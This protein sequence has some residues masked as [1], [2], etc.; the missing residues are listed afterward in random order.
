MWHIYN[1]DQRLQEL[2]DE[3]TGEVSDIAEMEM[4]QMEREEKIK[5]LALMEKEMELRISNIDRVIEELKE[6]KAKLN[7][8]A[9]KIIQF[10][11]VVLD[12]NNF[13]T[14]EVTCKFTPSVRVEID[15][16]DKLPKEYI[17]V[18]PEANKVVINKALRDGKEIEGA[19]LVHYI[20]LKIK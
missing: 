1:I 9:E 2:I 8:S 14:P 20:N 17:R 4:L 3:E 18:K 5:G 19:R 7:N 6:K 11:T 12:G 10:L 16:L 13:E 15:C